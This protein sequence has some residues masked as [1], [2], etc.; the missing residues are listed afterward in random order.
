HLRLHQL[1][2]RRLDGA[3]VPVDLRLRVQ[4]EPPEIR[5]ELSILITDLAPEQVSQRVGG[6]G[7]NEKGALAP[8]GEA[9]AERTAGG[10]LPPLPPSHRRTGPPA[11][12]ASVPD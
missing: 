10:R 7:G 8:P 12:R 4:L 11:G 9:K 5:C 2:H 3:E 1:P 6:V